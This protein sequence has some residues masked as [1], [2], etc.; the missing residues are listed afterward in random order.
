MEVCPP[1][2]IKLCSEFDS[3]EISEEGL[4]KAYTTTKIIFGSNYWTLTATEI[5][6]AFLGDPRLVFCEES[7]MFSQPLTHLVVAFEL[8]S[9]RCE[10]RPT[11]I[12][13][14]LTDSTRPL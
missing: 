9:S 6:T 11:W 10:L 8:V 7:V 14:L 3:S 5:T 1:P 12:K 4:Q 13:F 2:N